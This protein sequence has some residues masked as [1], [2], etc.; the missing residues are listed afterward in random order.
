MA[1]D[2]KQKQ[3][4]TTGLV[5]EIAEKQNEFFDTVNKKCDNMDNSIRLHDKKVDDVKDEL[6]KSILESSTKCDSLLQQLESKITTEENSRRDDVKYMKFDIILLKGINRN[7][8]TKFEELY[9][10]SDNLTEK[11]KNIFDTV[12]EM[13]KETQD[14][15]TRCQ[16]DVQNLHGIFC[17]FIFKKFTSFFLLRG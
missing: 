11:V 9:K 6:S 13:K 4:V 7:K 3:V 15:D 16:Q 17:I 2:V 8:D 12:G 1:E 10:K 5:T 14:L